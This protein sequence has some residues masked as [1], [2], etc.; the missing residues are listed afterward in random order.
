MLEQKD[1]LDFD[2]GGNTTELTRSFYHAN[3]L[4][5]VMAISDMNQAVTVGYRYDPYGSVTTSRG[6][7]PQTSDPLGQ[8]WGFTGRFLDEETGLFY[9]R[10]RYYDSTLGRFLQRDPLGYA[11]GASLFEY[12]ASAPPN[13]IDPTGLEVHVHPGLEGDEHGTYCVCPFW[14]CMCTIKCRWSAL[15]VGAMGD[16]IQ[17]TIQFGLCGLHGVPTAECKRSCE[18]ERTDTQTFANNNFGGLFV[19]TYNFP[20]GKPWMGDRGQPVLPVLDTPRGGWVVC[21]ATVDCVP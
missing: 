14:K 10:A 11:A 21:T 5:S 13:H 19:V 12:A 9:Y 16:T 17:Y 20:P 18:T 8:H 6:G 3:A 7:Q 1:V 15:L 4:G 2:S